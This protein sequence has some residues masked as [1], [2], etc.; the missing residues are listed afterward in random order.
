MNHVSMKKT[1][2]IIVWICLLLGFAQWASAQSNQVVKGKVTDEAGAAVIGANVAQKGTTIGTAT[3]E[4]G[5][6]TLSVP[7]NAT[8]VISY[9]G[10]VTKEIKVNNQSNLTIQLLED[11]QGL[12]EVVVTGYLSQK[13]L[14]MTAAASTVSN[15]ELTVTKNE[16]VVNMLAG[17]V[18]G[19]RITQRNAM[20]GAYNSVI[21][22]RG[23][24]DVV[25][26]NTGQRTTP[27]FVV[28]GVPRD[29]DYFSRM[30]PNEIETITVLKDASAAIYG[31]RAANGVILINTKTGTAQGGKVDISYSGSLTL[32]QM[33]YVPNNTNTGEWMTLKNEQNWQ[34][35]GNN[36]LIRRDPVY[37]DQTFQDYYN[38]TG[39]KDYNWINK[40]FAKD[41]TQT[42]H[43]VSID[44]GNDN[45]RYFFNL[46]YSKQNS[47]YN[48][49]SLWSENWNFRTN[50]DAKITK[51]LSAKI[52]VGAI[53]TNNHSPN[54]G[55]WDTYKNVW[56]QYP[57]APF[58]ANDN[59][60]YLNGDPNYVQNSD[61]P[62]AKTDSKYTGYS[63]NRDRRLNGTLTLNYDI[64]GVKGLSAKAM[65]DYTMFLPDNTSYNTV[66][67][68][69]QYD[70]TTQIYQ[71]IPRGGPA[72]IDRSTSNNF[73]TDMQ[74]G[75]AYANKFGKHSINSTLV[76]EEL[77]NTWEGFEAYRELSLPVPYLFAGNDLNQQGKAG[78]PGDH[79]RQSFIGEVNYDY[80]GKYLVDFRFREDGSSSYPKGSRWGFF[81]SLSLGWR[82]SEENFIKS[83]LNFLT[84]LKLR[85][86]YGVMGDDQAAN[87][88]PPI[89]VGYNLANQDRG[90]YFNDAASTLGVSPTAIPNPNLT[91]YTIKMTNLGL[92]F[93]ISQS[94]LYGTFD[95]F[96]RDRNGLLAD[97]GTV[98]PGTVGASLPQENLNSDR[99]F[100]W[101][102]ELGHRNRAGSVNYFVSANISSTR[103]MSISTLETPASNSFDYWKNRG[104]GRYQD[105]FWGTKAG[106]Y[107]TN[108]ADAR[109]FTNY[110]QPQ[111]VL[112]GDWYAVDWNG[113]GIINGDDDHPIATE[114]LPLFNYGISGGAD[115]K[116]FDLSFNFQG[117]Y[118][119]YSQYSEVFVEALPFG[120]ANTLYWFYDRWHPLDPNADLWSPNTQWVSGYYPITGRDGRRAWSNAINNTSYL[121]LKTLELGYTVPKKL[122]SKLSVKN[123]RVYV[124]GYNLLTISKTHG[125]DPERP[126]SNND[127]L[128]TYNGYVGMYQYPNNRTFTF[129]LNIKF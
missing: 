4:N 110:P 62:L 129:G 45:L 32:Q 67:D 88:Y 103:Q 33:I 93:D 109:N 122:L 49:G 100:G 30:D 80:A 87:N 40:V 127:L 10:Y 29:Q 46:G 19:V 106:G 59:P 44:G 12:G 94:K 89:Y 47:T 69:Y 114:G 61:N 42:Q 20:P 60:L 121:R 65:Y 43:N 53:L 6:F 34:D 71:A 107:F 125:I 18:P 101:E 24:S 68:I 5:N 117:S 75:L 108:I 58:Y 57:Y 11:T 41:P 124:N 63:I 27:L 16:N 55:T 23:M 70:P 78:A 28:D 104:S 123:L 25:D 14:N 128:N 85:A 112:P 79:L 31:L 105:I 113:D 51:R 64:P 86:S 72:S 97:K 120:G 36:F 91:W 22:I 98:I 119:V 84:N 17:K 52:Q 26:K 2:F 95:Y 74:L 3:D 15:K 96:I 77:Y 66:F 116:N 9:L 82:L 54:G 99:I 1:K 13:K 50:V 37:S 76:F 92:D 90:W 38:G 7:G 118:G 111:G 48:S 81:P 21:D 8:L 83:N 126:G 115:Y 56:L 102:L 35:F 73:D 39:Y